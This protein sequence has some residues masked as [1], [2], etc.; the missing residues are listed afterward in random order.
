[1]TL[2]PAGNFF[3]YYPRHRDFTRAH[4]VKKC[5]VN[6]KTEV[7]GLPLLC[8]ENTVQIGQWGLEAAFSDMTEISDFGER[9]T[10]KS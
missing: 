10:N 9:F 3:S 5:L 8:G 2:C 6:F 1:M 7:V 4:T